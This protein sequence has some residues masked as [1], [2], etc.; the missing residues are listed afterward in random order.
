[1]LKRFGVFALLV[2]FAAPALA[3]T[4]YY[5]PQVTG[6][7]YRKNVRHLLYVM[8]LAGDKK[9]VFD[10]YG[11]TPHRVRVN[12]YGYV[13]EHW[14]YLDDGIEFVFDDCSNLVKTHSIPV[15]HRRAWAGE[16]E[17]GDPIGSCDD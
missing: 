9:A 3:E 5:P 13:R 4:I 12:E 11:Y 6:K 2:L 1:M 15:E 10:E 14:K 16:Y 17:N 8:N 7:R